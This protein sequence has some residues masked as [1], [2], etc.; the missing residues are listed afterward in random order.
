MHA[1]VL[2]YAC[3]HTDYMHAYTRAAICML[4]LVLPYARV[5]TDYM[6]AYTRAAIC[7]A[8]TCAAICIRAYRLHACVRMRCTSRLLT[9]SVIRVP[10]AASG[11]INTYSYTSAWN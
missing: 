10:C 6:H 1:H 2:P 11:M 9:Q 3:V 4:T 8:Y 5:H 7:I